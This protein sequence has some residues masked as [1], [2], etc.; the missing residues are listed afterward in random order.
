MMGFRGIHLEIVANTS[1]RIAPNSVRNTISAPRSA[2]L[3]KLFRPW[4]VRLGLSQA[5]MSQAGAFDTHR[6]SRTW[7]GGH[8]KVTLWDDAKNKPQRR[9]ITTFGIPRQRRRRQTGSVGPDPPR[10]IKGKTV[11][12]KERTKTRMESTLLG[13]LRPRVI[14]LSP[15]G[16]WHGQAPRDDLEERE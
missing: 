15:T 11:I 4:R 6:R 2:H 7:K 5:K 8:W 10:R 9:Q 12:R 14:T 3:R 16:R 13:K 1:A